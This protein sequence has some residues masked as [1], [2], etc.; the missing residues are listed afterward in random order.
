MKNVLCALLVVTL[1][2]PATSA[3][4][5]DNTT[6]APS[7]FRASIARA[8]DRTDAAPPTQFASLPE[9][10]RPRKSADRS[11]KQMGGGGGGKMGMI[12]GLV[13]TAA[14]LGMTVYMVKAMKDNNDAASNAQ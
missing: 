11:R 1:V 4:A 6:A 5:A 12:L 9:A 10:P 7:V 14:G 2:A 13:G 3:L 8:V